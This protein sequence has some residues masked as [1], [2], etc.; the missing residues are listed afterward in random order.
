MENLQACV[1]QTLTPHSGD[2]SSLDY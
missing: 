1:S 2:F